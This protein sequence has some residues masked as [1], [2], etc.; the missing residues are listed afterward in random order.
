VQSLP[1]VVLRTSEGSSAGHASQH[2]TRKIKVSAA[3]LYT[4]F[5]KVFGICCGSVM[6]KSTLPLRR[7]IG[8]YSDFLHESSRQIAMLHLLVD[9][10]APALPELSRCNGSLLFELGTLILW[11]AVAL[12]HAPRLRFWVRIAYEENIAH[13]ENIFFMLHVSR[14]NSLPCRVS[15]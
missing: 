12:L 1:P 10:N 9:S 7:Q 14:A 3:L 2:Q 13:E 11:L 15:I 5:K 6:W 8:D 4:F